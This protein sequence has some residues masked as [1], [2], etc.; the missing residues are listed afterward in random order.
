M[1]A[2]KNDPLTRTI[3]IHSRFEGSLERND[4]QCDRGRSRLSERP[5]QTRKR[6]ARC[7]TFTHHDHGDLRKAVM[8]DKRPPRISSRRDFYRLAIRS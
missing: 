1:T 5:G 7:S 2:H 8:S 3:G 6:A 4:Q